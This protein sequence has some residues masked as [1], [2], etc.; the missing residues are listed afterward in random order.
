MGDFAFSMFRGNTFSFDVN[1]TQDGDPLDITNA[2]LT[3]AART[4]YLDVVVFTKTQD[5]GGGITILD[6]LNGK[7]RVALAPV[8]TKDLANIAEPLV[9]DLQL[10]DSCGQIFTIASG[11]IKVNPVAVPIPIP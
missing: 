5:P 9:A 10:V 2:V 6:A 11:T 1:I 7:A 8:D 4:S 3:F